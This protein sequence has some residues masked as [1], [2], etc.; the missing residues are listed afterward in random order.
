MFSVEGESLT[1]CFI[2]KYE[3]H[4]YDA[5]NLAMYKIQYKIHGD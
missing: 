2:I 4:V 1:I 5:I 3:S